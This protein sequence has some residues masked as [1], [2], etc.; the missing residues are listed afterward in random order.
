LGEITPITKWPNHDDPV[1]KVPTLVS[2]KNW[3]Y[4]WGYDVPD[5][6]IPFPWLW[7]VLLSDED[8]SGYTILN[9]EKIPE[10]NR[11]RGPLPSVHDLPAGHAISHYLRALWMHTVQTMADNLGSGIVDRTRFHIV[12]TLPTVW[13]RGGQRALRK[14]AKIAGLLHRRRAGVTKLTI[15]RRSTAAAQAAMYE[16]IRDARLG[17]SYVICYAGGRTMVS[18]RTWP[19]RSVVSR[20]SY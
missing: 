13:D 17:D 6:D 3:L 8:P 11:A 14:A 1:D 4:S 19:L 2:Y 18:T 7:A 9:T 16:S 12:L 15:V 10:I 20:E 5:T